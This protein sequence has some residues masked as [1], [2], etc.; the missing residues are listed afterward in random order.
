MRLRQF[1]V[2][3][4]YLTCGVCIILCII[5]RTRLSKSILTLVMPDPVCSIVRSLRDDQIELRA[6][7]V[8]FDTCFGPLYSVVSDNQSKSWQ[9]LR[10][11]VSSWVF[12]R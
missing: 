3:S 5:R 2:Q 7:S 9:P 4:E 8:D 12:F 11:L 1:V 10:L 6:A